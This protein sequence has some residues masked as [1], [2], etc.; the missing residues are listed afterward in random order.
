[1]M[2]AEHQGVITT[3]SSVTTTVL[4]AAAS[5]RIDFCSWCCGNSGMPPNGGALAGLAVD[6]LIT[7]RLSRPACFQLGVGT[8]GRAPGVGGLWSPS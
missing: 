2:S 3:A 8:W 6:P 7:W 4:H 5:V 1:V